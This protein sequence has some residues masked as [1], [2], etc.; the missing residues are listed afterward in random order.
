MVR[1]RNC[2]TGTDDEPTTG[3]GLILCREFVEKHGGPCGSTAK[4][5]KERPFTLPCPEVR[6]NCP[7]SINVTQCYPPPGNV[8]FNIFASVC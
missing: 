4:K 3:L 2:K 6:N 5:V 1:S 8:L 7:V